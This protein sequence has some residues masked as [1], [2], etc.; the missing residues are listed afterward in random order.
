MFA[1]LLV[2]KH[3][4][5]QFNDFYVKLL[6]RTNERLTL[7]YHDDSGENVPKHDSIH[8]GKTKIT[9]RRKSLIW[10]SFHKMEDFDWPRERR[11]GFLG[12]D[13]PMGIGFRFLGSDWPMGIGRR[14]LG[15]DWLTG[16]KGVGFIH[17]RRHPLRRLSF[18]SRRGVHP[19]LL[20]PP[21]RR[22]PRHN[23]RHPLHPG[24]LLS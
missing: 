18:S 11:H 15:S 6:V 10:E 5:L 9:N 16:Q 22:L 13:W 1:S 2:K 20:R 8:F 21:H 4:K 14:F 19:R 3:L 17:R 12:S 23:R 24:C 7:R